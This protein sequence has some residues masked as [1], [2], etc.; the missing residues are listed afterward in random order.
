MRISVDCLLIQIKPWLA[1]SPDEI[2][3]IVVETNLSGQS[4]G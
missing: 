3:G 2:D 1:A 4:K